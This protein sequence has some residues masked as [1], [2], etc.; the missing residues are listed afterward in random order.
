MLSTHAHL[1][2]VERVPGLPDEAG[3]VGIGEDLNLGSGERTG[4][5]DG[6]VEGES[7]I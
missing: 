3:R 5:R 2:L 6:A 7:G 4:G 1:R